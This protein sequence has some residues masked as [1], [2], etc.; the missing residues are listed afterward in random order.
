MA[1]KIYVTGQ[2]MGSLALVAK[3]K[4]DGTIVMRIYPLL[5][6]TRS[7]KPLN[8][9][10]YNKEDALVTFHFENSQAL[11]TFITFFNKMKDNQ[12]FIE[13]QTLAYDR[14]KTDYEQGVKSIF[15]YIDEIEGLLRPAGI[16]VV[17]AGM[18]LEGMPDGLFDVFLESVTKEVARREKAKRTDNKEE[19]TG[20]PESVAN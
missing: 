2:D 7:R 17:Q 16:K 5:L 4:R 10:E 12:I 19:K 8:A 18:G 3:H 13:G 11:D 15:D 14:M 1:T 9:N 6:R 20:Q